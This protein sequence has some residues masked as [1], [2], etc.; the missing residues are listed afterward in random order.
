MRKGSATAPATIADQARDRAAVV[1]CAPISPGIETLRVESASGLGCQPPPTGPGRSAKQL[2]AGPSLIRAAGP[3]PYAP[4]D[5]FSPSLVV[6]DCLSRRPV[7]SEPLLTTLVS[8]PLLQQF[9][10][11]DP[12]M[13]CPYNTLLHHH[14]SRS[15]ST[16]PLS[17]H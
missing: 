10:I 4:P 11:S 5:N 3:S 15:L 12:V 9:S 6:V 16:D 1:D 17:R 2:P 7:L 14:R 13:V 8:S